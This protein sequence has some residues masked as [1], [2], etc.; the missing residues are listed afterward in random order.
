MKLQYFILIIFLGSSIYLLGQ[1]KVSGVVTDTNNT[2]LAGVNIIVKGTNIGVTTGYNG[3]FSIATNQKKTFE[4][5]FSYLGFKT[6]IISVSGNTNDL[7]VELEE[8]GGNLDEIVISATRQAEKITRA[9]S[10]VNIITSKGI[11][12]KIT[13][14]YLELIEGG[15]GVDFIQKGVNSFDIN[16]RGFSSTF[17]TSTLY[18]TDDR[19]SNI[20]SA[21]IPYQILNPLVKEDIDR[22]EVVLGPSSSLYGAN[23]FSGLVNIQ[24]KNPFKKQG[25]DISQTFGNQGVLSTRISTRHRLSNRVAFKVNT[26][27]TVWE[28]FK[29]V[30][31]LYIPVASST[32]NIPLA[33]IGLVNNHQS[34]KI[35]GSI[36]F[37]LNTDKELIFDTGY[38]ISDYIA[39]TSI[40]RNYYKDW[41]I[42][43]QQVRYTSPKLYAQ[44]SYN[45]EK[46]DNSYTISTA[47]FFNF[48]PA[49]H[50]LGTGG[51]EA[52]AIQRAAFI[53]NND[54]WTGEI[55]Y[56]NKIG[57]NFSYIIG[58]QGLFDSAESEQTSLNDFNGPVKQNIISSY[59]HA[60][61]LISE[62]I[63]AIASLRLDNHNKI[64]ASLSPKF[65]LLYY[66]AEN[67]TLRF[68]YG[69]GFKFPT[70]QEYNAFILGGLFYGGQ[71]RGFTLQDGTEIDALQPTIVN[72][73]EL[74]YK[75]SIDSYKWFIDANLFYEINEDFIISTA[76]GSPTNPVV[77][78]GNIPAADFPGAAATGVFNSYVNFGRVDTY[79]LDIGLNYRFSNH[80][81]ARF[82]YSYFK[83]NKKLD[84]SDLPIVDVNQNGVVDESEAPINTPANKFSFALNYSK[85]KFFGNISGR[86][87]QEYNYYNSLLIA[88]ESKDFPYL[89]EQPNIQE[90]EVVITNN[91]LGGYFN[92]GPLGGFLNVNINAGYK[93]LNWLAVN[94]SVSNLFDV[95]Q[96][97]IAGTPSIGRLYKAGVKLKF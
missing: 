40:G 37:K 65:A 17:N 14:N 27:R 88:S 3:K 55:Q 41:E 59:I 60:D 49:A 38:S 43:Y 44:I 93:L 25:T 35:N 46:N 32:A 23:A 69:R 18:L 10:A 90:N 89:A 84:N 5:K 53:N 34:F 21:N 85:D 28:D 13:P 15:K 67:S 92:R 68:T 57:S 30:D 12:Q 77:S 9:P 36:H 48:L 7:K 87:T 75:A 81:S 22:M 71:D 82:N 24:T 11:E 29:F 72:S 73:F 78:S 58:L 33:E 16:I 79:G 52:A 95:E 76:V 63:K 66:T 8:S 4:L 91:V 45:S 83:A 97:D 56:N 86:Y 61:Y 6:K 54:R 26:E 20:I 80:L 19:I 96:R 50:P 47:T 51:D 1:T 62:K 31:S 42:N 94:G 64:G 70:I 39:P 74:G 2:P